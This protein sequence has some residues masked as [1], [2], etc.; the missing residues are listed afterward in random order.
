MK[1]ILSVSILFSLLISCV[2][3]AKKETRQISS[4]KMESSL[5]GENVFEELD[6]FESHRDKFRRDTFLLADK[7]TEGGELVVFHPIE[8]DFL[9][10]DF[11]LYGE[12]GK[13]NLTYITNKDYAFK[14]V[15]RVVFKYD[16]PMYEP[17][18]KERFT[19]EYILFEG[20]MATGYFDAFKQQKSISKEELLEKGKSS[21]KEFFELTNGLKIVK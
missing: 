3:S 9:V 4:N 2:D 1:L 14:M 6:Y 19:E 7:S 12:M 5:S 21:K 13:Q 10:F 20:E 18:Y 15:K 16:K 8:T 17:G 11:W